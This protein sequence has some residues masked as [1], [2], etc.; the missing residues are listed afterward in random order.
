MTEIRLN[1]GSILWSH[2][3][4]TEGHQC[5]SHIVMLPCFFRRLGHENKCTSSV[6]WA[7][8]SSWSASQVFAIHFKPWDGHQETED[9]SPA[10][11]RL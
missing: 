7:I 4:E 10:L 11:R 1:M 2:R 8:N 6:R 9:F 5:I 3:N